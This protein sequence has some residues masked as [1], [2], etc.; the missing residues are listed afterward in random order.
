MSE[1]KK[2]E[3]KPD[4]TIAGRD[5]FFDKRRITR[6]EWR[7][8]WEPNIT[9]EE[10]NGI[11]SKFAGVPGDWLDALNLNDYQLFIRAATACVQSPPDPN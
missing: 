4:V 5:V 8:V 2:E 7:R 1:E 10:E 9:D 11:L 6:K 3:K